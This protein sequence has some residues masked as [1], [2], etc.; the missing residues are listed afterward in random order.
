MRVALASAE[1]QLAL[2]HSHLLGV[3][4][5]AFKAGG[6]S[7][8]DIIAVDR[9]VPNGVSVVLCSAE[10]ESYRNP[11]PGVTCG[12]PGFTQ[13]SASGPYRVLVRER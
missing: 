5:T 7:R 3:S 9:D 11:A 8:S 13:I 4:T 10:G 2:Q 12:F 1:T 6:M